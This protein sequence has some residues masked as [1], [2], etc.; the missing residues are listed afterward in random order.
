MI[1]QQAINPMPRHISG[2]V[3][4]PPLIM[5]VSGTSGSGSSSVS[6]AN[7]TGSAA[8]EMRMSEPAFGLRYRIGAAGGRTGFASR[9]S[10]ISAGAEGCDDDVDTTF[11][12]NVLGGLSAA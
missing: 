7:S 8:A 4:P 3:H 2:M 9:W 10:A 11:G 12:A 5:E 6:S 1:T